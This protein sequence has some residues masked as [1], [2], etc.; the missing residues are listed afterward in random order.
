MNPNSPDG[1]RQR[2]KN[3]QASKPSAKKKKPERWLGW[4]AICLIAAVVS[5]L[6][7][8]G[9]FLYRTTNASRLAPIMSPI[10]GIET[11]KVSGSLFKTLICLEFMG[12]V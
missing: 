11:D 3:V 9:I 2:K 10:V 7:F 6:L 4:T 12:H 8:T 5:V 1:L